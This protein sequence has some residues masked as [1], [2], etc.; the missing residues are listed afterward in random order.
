MITLQ[1]MK[2]LTSQLEFAATSDDIGRA[3]LS[4][5]DHFGLTGLLLVDARKL[6][7]R[8]GPAIVF[9]SGDRRA[10]DAFDAARPLLTGP[11]FSRAQASDTPFTFS[12]MR[13]GLGFKEEGTWWHSFAGGDKHKDGLAV[14][15]HEN[16]RMV[17]GAGFT[18]RDPDLS[19]EC[20]SVLSAAVYAAYAR[21]QDLLDSNTARSPLSARESECLHWVS[22][23]KTDFEVG[24]ILAIS[25]RTVRFHISNAKAKLG[26][27]T[28]IQAVT[29]RFAQG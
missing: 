8:A 4:A 13:Q 10:I 19:Q 29:K 6:F 3:L 17:W 23:G 21:F 14:P 22:A 18:G 16:G 2:Q 25:A 1:L 5:S 26:V 27:T 11:A 28:R 12:E 15:V 9:T 24:K 20:R 7:S